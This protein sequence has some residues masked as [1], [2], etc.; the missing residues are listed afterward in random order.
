MKAGIQE[1]PEQE[2]I[3]YL[4]HKYTLKKHLYGRIHTSEN[5]GFTGEKFSKRIKVGMHTA[6]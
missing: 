3:T 1:C 4:P 6:Q 2:S 5:A